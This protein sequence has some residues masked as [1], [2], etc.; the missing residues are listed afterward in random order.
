MVSHRFVAGSGFIVEPDIAQWRL[1][2]SVVFSGRRGA[3]LERFGA[4]VYSDLVWAF[5]DCRAGAPARDRLLNPRLSLTLRGGWD[6]GF[7][8]FRFS[9][10]YDQRLFRNYAIELPTPTG[11]DT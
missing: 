10:G 5:P 6:L 3:L 1:L 7:T 11:P 2:P 8:G 9:Y 4:S